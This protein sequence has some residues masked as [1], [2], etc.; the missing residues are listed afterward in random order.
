MIISQSPDMFQAHSRI[1]R[2]NEASPS[3]SPMAATTAAAAAAS[4][5]VLNTSTD[6]NLDDDPNSSIMNKVRSRVSSILPDALSKWFSPAKRPRDT[7]SGGSSNEQNSSVNSPA[8]RNGNLLRRE[9]RLRQFGFGESD[10]AD[11]ERQQQRGQYDPEDEDDGEE[12]ED[13]DHAP[14]IRKKKRMEEGF[15]ATMVDFNEDLSA[16]PGPSGLNIS[17]IDRRSSLPVAAT[18]VQL[19][20]YYRNT[21]SS[22]TPSTSPQ[23]HQMLNRPQQ[24]TSLIG[25][26]NR[27]TAPYNFGVSSGPIAEE[28]VA[29]ESLS[30]SIRQRKGIRE[31]SS[32]KR[33][34]IPQMPVDR[35][36][37]EPPPPI[38]GRRFPLQTLSQQQQLQEEGSTEELR[39][40]GNPLSNGNLNESAS[41]SSSVSNLNLSQTEGHPDTGRR[42]SAY[43]G[44]CP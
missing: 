4:G 28:Q 30:L 31:I 24:R 19:P 42:L 25:Y 35:S 37:S 13:E 22:S 3:S 39:E 17:A 29:N 11:A 38:F 26:T 43:F 21:F 32:R 16:V 10:L 27:V 23:Q 20:Q 40:E 1:T 34:N 15:N 12:E 36:T 18:S 14:P 33:L 2:S 44:C 41:E 5:A 7:G 6:S 8:G 9:N